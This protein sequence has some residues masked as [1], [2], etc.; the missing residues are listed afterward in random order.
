MKKRYNRKSMRLKGYDYRSPG[1]YF[2]T[3]CTKNRRQ[4]FGHIK[5]EKMH[6]SKIG[7]LADK[8][9]REI[10]DHFPNAQ[11]GEY[12]V[13]PDHVHGIVELL[14]IACRAVACNGPTA[15]SH[16]SISPKSGSLS[17]LI[18]SYKSAVTKDSRPFEPQFEWQE[19]FHDRIVRISDP[20]HK[21]R[22]AQYI[23]N[24][25]KNWRK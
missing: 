1:F 17:A 16:S 18:R 15:I 12:V 2:I 5:D 21:Y 13:M 8:F 9:F 22:I 10:P 14:D 23:I 20:G 6:L 3:I 25:P 7:L 4:F 11:L 24:N 19:R